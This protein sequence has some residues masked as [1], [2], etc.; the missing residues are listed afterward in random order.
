[1]E[2]FEYIFVSIFAI[3][4]G[5]FLNVLIY[6]LPKNISIISP[7]S[8]CPKCKSKIPWYY[9]I[10]IFS[11]VFLRAKCFS[12]KKSISYT[13]FFVELIAIVFA[14]FLYEKL[15][16]SLAFI[17][18]IIL[19]YLLIVL[20]FIDIKY[21][22]VP[23]YLLLIVLVLS[24]F[25]SP[26]TFFDSLQNAFLFSGAF[27]LLNFFISFY[28]QNI[29]A[30]YLKN[31][32]L[33]GQKALGEGDIPIIASMAVLLGLQGGVFAIFLTS[34]F[35]IILTLVYKNKNLEIPFIP[36]LLL[37]LSLEYLFEISKVL[38]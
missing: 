35:A 32:S 18:N 26:F 17:L 22:A 28:I 29:K 4:F 1:M 36:Y 15:G 14:L 30:K 38:S 24:F 12:C 9:N 33:K 20:A 7:R 19:F 10:P 37:G 34:V 2:L 11:F 3:C 31:D 23:D 16:F 21:K 13:Y 6:R 5:S 27:V 25:A 8:F